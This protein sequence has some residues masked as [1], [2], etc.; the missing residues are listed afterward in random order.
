MSDFR[1][2]RKLSVFFNS[3]NHI[4]QLKSLISYIDNCHEIEQRS[5]Y[6]VHYIDIYGVFIEAMNAYESKNK[7]LNSSEI[8][9]HLKVVKLMLQ[10]M[11]YRIRTKWE[12][13]SLTHVIRC[14]LHHD[15]KH[16]VRILGFE[17]LLLLIDAL[18]ESV[19]QEIVDILSSVIDYRSFKRYYEDNDY[20]DL[21]MLLP[22][23]LYNNYGNSVLLTA[24]RSYIATEEETLE[25]LDFFFKTLDT[26]P[27]KNF[28]F[29]WN[30]VIEQVLQIYWPKTYNKT[31]GFFGFN[32]PASVVNLIVSYI[33]RWLGR[34]Y[35][36]T[37]IC[38]DIPNS[39][40]IVHIISCG[41][42]LNAIYTKTVF[43]V[44]SLIRRWLSNQELPHAFEDPNASHLFLM[45][46]NALPFVAYAEANSETDKVCELALETI[47]NVLISMDAGINI[48][49][50]KWK[51]IHKSLLSFVDL[52]LKDT[53]ERC[54]ASKTIELLFECIIKSE[55]LQHIFWVSLNDSS[56]K[57]WGNHVV[58][59]QQWRKITL[60]L[61]RYVSQKMFDTTY[62]QQH[63]VDQQLKLKIGEDEDSI[64]LMSKFWMRFMNLFSKP[65]SITNDKAHVVIVELFRDVVET[66]MTSSQKG[67]LSAYPNRKTMVA[68]VGYPLLEFLGNNETHMPI[69]STASSI[70]VQVINYIMSNCTYIIDD[71]EKEFPSLPSINKFNMNKFMG[72]YITA[73]SRVLQ[74]SLFDDPSPI[75]ACCSSMLSLIKSDIDGQ[76]FWLSDVMEAIKT[77]LHENKIPPTSLSGL[78]DLLCGYCPIVFTLGK[79]DVPGKG[80]VLQ[81]ESLYVNLMIEAIQVVKSVLGRQPNLVT[82]QKLL[83]DLCWSLSN[84]IS[85][86]LE[87]TKDNEG[88][89]PLISKM[90]D[91]L[92]NLAELKNNPN[93]TSVALQAIG[94]IPELAGKCISGQ[95]LAPYV[96]EELC[97]LI[98]TRVCEFVPPTGSSGSNLLNFTMVSVIKSFF[99]LQYWL[100][101]YPEVIEKH[102]ELMRLIL[103]TMKLCIDGED[104]S[105]DTSDPIAIAQFKSTEKARLFAKHP[106]TRSCV[107]SAISFRA[108]VLFRFN[109]FP[110]ID[111]SL[112]VELDNCEAGKN[113]LYFALGYSTIGSIS[114]LET[115]NEEQQP[116]VRLILRTI[117]GKYGFDISIENKFDTWILERKGSKVP[118]IQ[119]KGQLPPLDA[120]IQ[121]DC[122]FAFSNDRIR[123][124][125]DMLGEFFG[126]IENDEELTELFL[127][128]QEPVTTVIDEQVEIL[129]QLRDQTEILEKIPR[130]DESFGDSYVAEQNI[131]PA[132]GMRLIRKVLL[133]MGLL[134]P[135]EE[136][137]HFCRYIEPNDAFLDCI[138]Q[139]DSKN[140]RDLVTCGLMFGG[141]NQRHSK[142]IINNTTISKGFLEFQKSL[143]IAQ[144]PSSRH[145]PVGLNFQG[146]LFIDS[147]EFQEIVYYCAPEF[148]KNG[149][150]GEKLIR[151]SPVLILYS[152]EPE[153]SS[154]LYSNIDDFNKLPGVSQATK[155]I[156]IVHPIEKYG[157][158]LFSTEVILADTTVSLGSLPKITLL[159]KDRLAKFIKIFVRYCNIPS[160]ATFQ[161]STSFWNR[162]TFLDQIIDDFC[163][164][165]ENGQFVAHLLGTKLRGKN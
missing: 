46:I 122:P 78:I 103:S 27:S 105:P 36:Q 144:M 25:I 24:K 124:H 8:C 147:D 152:E 70:A 35:P 4:K 159:N 77:L 33:V 143:G 29:Y 99:A 20:E 137:S 106:A 63:I 3:N 22:K 18:G 83:C 104:F 93:I 72:K 125:V 21:M 37:I 101:N 161:L 54:F 158:N 51:S 84:S 100:K 71:D 121:P 90:I 86:I 114:S 76:F 23:P 38:F 156:L 89:N 16:N 42:Q 65:M 138:Q 2:N 43:S 150:D 55:N 113:E 154:S 45:M 49:E 102:T 91:C 58:F 98:R 88:D 129:E 142:A 64:L 1:S 9:S 119:E 145:L 151:G 116:M 130:S 131:L 155:A 85:L 162:Q 68:L 81:Y 26:V 164:E 132:S 6:S 40:R 30:I 73:I 32:P 74:G 17:M 19:D 148:C 82:I 28:S 12:F 48:F 136:I 140:V 139:L 44:L 141:K 108:F 163:P 107:E 50:D 52:A 7:T 59:L 135:C 87:N 157:A 149:I 41:L 53:Q 61:T 97:N 67:N 160:K 10:F 112:A 15:N 56:T 96:I 13:G 39:E 146:P 153:I 109:M 47:N 134:T 69:S 127:V 126:E 14:A 75:Y 62:L 31:Q 11:P 80:T 118:Q 165:S 117:A 128:A 60:F 66:L 95:I 5:F 57:K 111:D 115:V 133:S 120:E 79:L 34:P 94:C 110:F 92:F 123:N